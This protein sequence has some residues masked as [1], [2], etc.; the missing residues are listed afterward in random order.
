MMNV[1]EHELKLK[2]M[3]DMYYKDYVVVIVKG[4]EIEYSRILTVFSI[5]DLSSNKFIG[6]IPKSIG[7]LNSLWGLN[8]SHN[9]LKGHIP[10]SL[11]NLSNLESLDLSSNQ[12]VGGIPQQLTS[13]MFLAVLNLSYNHLVGQ[14]PQGRQFNTFGKDSYNGN[15]DLCGFPLSKKCEELQPLPPPP[16]LHEDE[17]SDRSSGFSWKVVAMGY[18]CGFVFGMVMGYLMFVTRKPEWL[19]KIAE[20]KQYKKVCNMEEPLEIPI[21]NDLTMVLGSISQLIDPLDTWEDEAK[22]IDEDGSAKL[23]IHQ[24][25]KLKSSS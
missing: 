15:W 11:G 23:A 8:L 14:I 2:Y 18:G 1:D 17:N 25:P 10:T 3:G 19:M 21:M 12:L 16:T 13:L 5:I 6:E 4:H 7:R 24:L 20:G 22:L 9:N